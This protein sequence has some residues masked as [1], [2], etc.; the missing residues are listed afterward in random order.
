MTD[1]QELSELAAELSAALD[2]G[3]IRVVYLPTVS[4][5][6]DSI[7][8][9]EA[10]LRWEHPT[11]GDIP[12]ARFI[13]AAEQTGLIIRLGRWVLEQ[14]CREAAGWPARADGARRVVSVNVSAMQLADPDFPGAM[15]QALTDAGLEANRVQ[16]ELTE[17]VVLDTTG[18]AL[19]VLDA[20]VDLG[21]QIAIDDFGTG[22][23]NLVY[24]QHLPVDTVKLAGPFITDLAPPAEDP[25]VDERDDPIP[26]ARTHDRG[27]R[28]RG[29]RTADPILTATVIEL[30]HTLGQT[31]TAEQVETRAQADRLRELGCDD[32]QG[33]HYHRP[34]TS[35]ALRALLAGGR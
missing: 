13:A 6:D 3:E 26:G 27:D 16:L 2:R 1:Q 21:V 32:A 34:L 15:K 9:A 22:Y 10:L 19:D 12:P 23:S 24:L 11:H 14:A 18:V 7:V 28:R 30:A 31:V 35:D 4:L 17:S 20:V 25:V 29:P 8:G 5:A 33:W